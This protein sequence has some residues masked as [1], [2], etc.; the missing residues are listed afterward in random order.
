MLNV[1]KMPAY[2]NNT[3]DVIQ[4]YVEMNIRCGVSLCEFLVHKKYNFFHLNKQTNK[5]RNTH[6]FEQNR[7]IKQTFC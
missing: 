4:R 5:K 6:S 3:L 1:L 7:S 2:D